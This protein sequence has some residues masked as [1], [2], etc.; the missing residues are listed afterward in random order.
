MEG[1]VKKAERSLTAL[2]AGL[3][4]QRFVGLVQIGRDRQTRIAPSGDYYLA[5]LIAGAAEAAA[6]VDQILVILLLEDFG[7]ALRAAAGHASNY[8]RLV[9]GQ[10]LLDHFDEIRIGFHLARPL[11]E[12]DRN[13][14]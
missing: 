8:Q 4:A 1:I 5:A 2:Q 13:I 12:N 7:G 3:F 6:D 11:D 10:Y 9:F 14:N